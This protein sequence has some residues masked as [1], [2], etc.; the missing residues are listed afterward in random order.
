MERIEYR[1][2]KGQAAALS[3]PLE[4]IRSAAVVALVGL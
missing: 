2:V 1:K 3:H 4:L